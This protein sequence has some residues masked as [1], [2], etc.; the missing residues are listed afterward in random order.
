MKECSK[1]GL[2]CHLPEASAQGLLRCK[3]LQRSGRPSGSSRVGSQGVQEPLKRGAIGAIF[4]P[5][6]PEFGVSEPGFGLPV[7]FCTGPHQFQ[8]FWTSVKVFCV[9]RPFLAGIRAFGARIRIPRE[10]LYRIAFI[11][12]LLDLCE[13]I[14]DHFSIRKF[15]QRSG[16]PSGWSRVG[17]QGVRGSWGRPGEPSRGLPWP[18]LDGF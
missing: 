4:G 17:S 14:S 12:Q 2:R 8:N 13:A 10:S 7:K 15:L 3:F 1:G 11:S 6:W 18:C 9:F 16:R 5:F